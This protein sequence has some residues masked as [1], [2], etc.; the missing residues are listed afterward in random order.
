[1]RLPM[2]GVRGWGSEKDKQAARR[3]YAL[4]GH[5]RKLWGGRRATGATRDA[6]VLLGI[7]LPEGFTFVRPR[8]RGEGERPADPAPNSAGE[9]EGA[10]DGGRGS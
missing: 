8:V 7:V 2:A 9:G 1:V 3:A 6:A 5:L 4:R 10:C